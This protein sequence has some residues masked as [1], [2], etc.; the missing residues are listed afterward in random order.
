MIEI[1][2]YKK[3]IRLVEGKIEKTNLLK[4]HY[5]SKWYF[6]EC[7]YNDLAIHFIFLI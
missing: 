4:K 6:Y 5:C 7:G 2:K 3:K 1:N